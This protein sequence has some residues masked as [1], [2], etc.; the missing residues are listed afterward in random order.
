MKRLPL[1]VI[2]LTTIF[3]T[4]CI[5]PAIAQARKRVAILSFDD[6]N[7]Q[8]RI[9]GIGQRITDELISALAGAGSFEIIDREYLVKIMNEQNRGYSNRFDAEG[10]AKIGKLANANI[11]IVGQVDSFI[12][13]VSEE[14]KSSILGAKI[15]H[16]GN[17]S[18]KVTA[19]IIQVDTAT[20][21]QAPSVLTEQKA[22]LSQSSSYAATP[23]IGM[24]IPSRSTRGN[25][26]G[27]EKLVDQAVHDAVAQLTT[28]ITAATLVVPATIAIPKFVGVEDGLIVVNKGKAAGIRV[29]DQFEVSRIAATGMK[30]PDTG[31][32]IKRKK[33]M[34]VFT[35]LVVEE[36]ISSGKC[37]GSAE[38][39]SGDIF[40]PIPKQ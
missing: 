27:I 10:A 23:I 26:G 37:D 18:L 19:R 3:T 12:A 25:G 22:V 21:L 4:V 17:V 7:A 38:P 39:Q 31:E 24:G 9:H 15:T 40:N 28:K 20:I 36:A 34:C 32:E 29:G 6:R 11:L 8:T 5:T 14:N 30:D 16:N 13:N 33:K 2:L 1:V 35:V